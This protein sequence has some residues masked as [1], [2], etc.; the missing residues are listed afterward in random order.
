MWTTGVL[1]VLTHCHIT[2]AYYSPCG[3]FFLRRWS[4]VY[5]L[6]NCYNFQWGY[7]LWCSYITINYDLWGLNMGSNGGT[8][9]GSAGFL[10]DYCDLAGGPCWGAALWSSYLGDE[11]WR[12]PMIHLWYSMT[13]YMYIYMYV[14]VYVHIYIYI[15]IIYMPAILP[16]PHPRMRMNACSMSAFRSW[17]SGLTSSSPWR[18]TGNQQLQD[19][20]REGL[21]S[22]GRLLETPWIS[23]FTQ[24]GHG[25]IYSFIVQS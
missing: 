20:R 8:N 4:I 23:Q 9:A 22:R 18:W 12:T 21:V 14:Y 25:F 6:Y 5:K 11:S 10:C 13:M 2:R 19:T 1:L 15:I 7:T 3:E 16:K 24:I 17:P